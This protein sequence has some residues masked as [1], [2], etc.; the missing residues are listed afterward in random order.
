MDSGREEFERIDDDHI[1]EQN[2]SR[3]EQIIVQEEIMESD[4]EAFV[5]LL[6]E[7]DVVCPVCEGTGKDYF[8]DDCALCDGIGMLLEYGDG[9]HRCADESET[10][11][12]IGDQKPERYRSTNT[13]WQKIHITVDS[14]PMHRESRQSDNVRGERHEGE[15]V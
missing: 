10:M 4:M 6:Q 15:D 3:Y 9:D 7:T 12:A 5:G 2:V 8:H 14:G 11:Y 13:D 1:I